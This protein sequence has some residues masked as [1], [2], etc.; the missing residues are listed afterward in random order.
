M[1]HL[2]VLVTMAP[3]ISNATAAEIPAGTHL[4]LSLE[5]TIDTKTVKVG[6]AVYLRTLI[7]IPA[8]G[9]IAVPVGSY[10]EG[11]VTRLKRDDLQIELSRIILPSGGVLNTPSRSTMAPDKRGTHHRPSALKLVAITGLSALN[12]GLLG[13][14]VGAV[15]TDSAKG[16]GIGAGVGAGVGVAMPV[17]M[18]IVV[19]HQRLVFRQ[20]LTLEV[21]F[22]Q[23]VEL[24]D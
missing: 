10:A 24:P 12:A 20:G 7:P 2:I 5:H 8:G 17:A 14:L 9:G 11:V 19:R 4:L 22:D 21:V 3:L 6:D 1:K 23:P 18:V 13:A 15:I 16:A